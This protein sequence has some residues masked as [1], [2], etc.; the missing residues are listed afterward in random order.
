MGVESNGM[1]M[2]GNLDGEPILLQFLEEVPPG[3]PIT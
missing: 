1:I 3:S 2:A